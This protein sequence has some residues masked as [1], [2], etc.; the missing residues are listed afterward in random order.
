MNNIEI[1]AP[2]SSLDAMAR[3]AEAWGAVRQGVLGQR[4]TFFVVPIGYLKLREIEGQ[5][6]ELIAYSRERGH[7]PRASDYVVAAV[8]NP[9]A[10]EDALTRAL[11]MRG[12]VEKIRTLYLW[13]H[14]RIHLDK[15]K[16]LGVFL[17]LET[18]MEGL[19]R[20]PAEAEAW[21]IIRGLDLDPGTF[22]DV[23]YLELLET[24]S[25]PHP[26]SGAPWQEERQ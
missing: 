3:K 14:T 13:K 16:G 15:V 1:K 19:D 23:P 2:L 7:G 24:G 22:L 6:G 9:R 5:G 11:G 8:K 4:D 10:V 12:R 17:E 26:A 21:S 25:Y 18:V 20:V